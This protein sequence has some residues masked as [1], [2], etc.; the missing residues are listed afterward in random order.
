MQ[1]TNNPLDKIEQEDNARKSPKND[2]LAEELHRETAR[3]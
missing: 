1:S 3:S 2:E